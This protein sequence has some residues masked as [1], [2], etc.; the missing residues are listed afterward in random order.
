MQD[1]ELLE[2]EY[3]IHL[4][5]NAQNCA[6]V[7]TGTAA[8]HVAIEAMELSPDS[9]IIVPEFTMYASALS[10]FYARLQMKF[11][12]CDDNLLIN[13][14]EVEKILE[15][16]KD[17]KVK[18]LMITHVYGRTVD[19]KRVDYL[20]RRFG[21]RVIE[22]ACESQTGLTNLDI[23][24]GTYDIGCFSFYRNK[25]I[26]AEEGGLVFAKDTSLIKKIRDMRSMSFGSTHDYYHAQIG[27]NY[28]MTN[29]QARLALTSLQGVNESLARRQQITNY[30]NA[31]IDPK[32]QMINNR[33]AIWVYD[34]IHPNA[35]LVVKNLKNIGINAR[36]SFK[37]MSMQ[38]L[39]EK[40]KNNPELYKNALKMSNNVFYVHC[41]DDFDISNIQKITDRINETCKS[42]L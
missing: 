32:F 16:D 4:G 13:L 30:L 39:F 8:L 17:R 40:W 34:M 41:G 38:P 10:V 11:V 36:H 19:M 20:A 15:L 27:F 9:V 7:N 18:V 37:P 35:D 21:I 28:R 12:D 33:K 5:H 31:N 26:C 3:A 24:S 23:Q 25:I 14:D 42:N 29:S 6:V 22:D 1:F 2:S